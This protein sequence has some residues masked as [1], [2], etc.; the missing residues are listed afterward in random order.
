MSVVERE[1]GEPSA[2][3]VYQQEGKEPL[4]VCAEH[5]EWIEGIAKF[6]GFR[7]E[8]GQPDGWCQVMLRYKQ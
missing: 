3:S 4:Q 8:P 6:S 2:L 1:C 5:R 7:T